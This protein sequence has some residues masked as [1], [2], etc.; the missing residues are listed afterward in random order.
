MRQRT[1][2]YVP[3]VNTHPSASTTSAALLQHTS[4]YVSIPAVQ[5]H[6]SASTASGTSLMLGGSAGLLHVS[7]R[8]HTSAYVS[9]RQH[10]YAYLS[11]GVSAQSFTVPSWEAEDTC[12]RLSQHTSA[13]VSM[14]QHTSAYLS[15]HQHTS[16]YVS[17]RGG[18]LPGVECERFNSRRS[19]REHHPRHYLHHTSAYVSIRQHTSAHVSVRQDASAYVSIRQ[20]TSAHVS[21][22]QHMPAY[23]SI[24]QHLIG[25]SGVVN[26]LAGRLRLA[27]TPPEAQLVITSSSTCPP[28]AYVSIS[29]HTS[30]YVSMRQRTSAY[31][32]APPA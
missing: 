26:A 11:R 29:Q 14:R 6:S 8:Q 9:I 15:I 12:A 5:A 27:R 13:Y 30:A 10:T 21:I 19:V 20:H 28:L 7:I 2:A 16:A 25:S 32:S 22:R 23:A 4:A 24:R 1:P 18:D 17:I 3:A 31:R